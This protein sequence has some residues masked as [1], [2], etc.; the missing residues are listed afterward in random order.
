MDI[1]HDEDQLIFTTDQN[2]IYKMGISLVD[3]KNV[4]TAYEYLVHQFHSRLIQGMDVCIKK[5]L[6][7]TC[8]A[9]KTVK[10]WS[11]HPT[12]GFNLEINESY[13]EETLSVAFHPAGFQ[14]VVGFYDRV[15]MMNVFQDSIQ[16][17]KELPYKGCR[18]IV[19][20]NGGHLFA[21][22]F[23]TF[24]HVFKF[25]T[26]ECPV[27]YIFKAHQGHVRSIAWLDDD[28]GFVTSALDASIMCW[29]LNPSDG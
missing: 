4:E 23:Q 3:T 29:K 26:A 28:T 18:E 20:S 21:C 11:Y 2:Q 12:M 24:V 10:I 25:F 8:S 19:F 16:Q 13:T 14:I 7:V 27:N 17:Y 6:V 22:Q 15:R 5:N 9:D 1:S